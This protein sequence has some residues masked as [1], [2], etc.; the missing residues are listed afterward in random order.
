LGDEFEATLRGA[1]RGRARAWDALYS[2]FAPLV[3]GYL[4]ARRFPEP[5]DVCAETFL[6]VVR[7]LDRFSGDE[8]GFRAWILSI[9]HH[10]GCDARRRASRRP[11]DPAP[12]E[13]IELELPPVGTDDE[14]F[15]RIAEREVTQLLTIL[16][17]EQQEVMLLR[18]LGGMTT[19]EIAE[20]TGRKREA[21]KGLQKRA[22]ARLRAHLVVTDAAGVLAG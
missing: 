2:E 12:H 16:S 4:R 10:R 9:A 5:E 13:A 11:S 21:V 19:S 22:I 6:Q 15:G 18:L 17:T 3:L 1:R 20:L 7:D 8:R 14:I